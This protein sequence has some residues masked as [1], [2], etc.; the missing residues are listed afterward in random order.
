[1]DPKDA[2]KKIAEALEKLKILSR[3]WGYLELVCLSEG[4]WVLRNHADQ[5]FGNLLGVRKRF[6]ADTPEDVI[7]VA[8]K[9]HETFN[10]SEERKE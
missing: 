9:A 1:M 4:R 2:W 5:E 7:F 8:Y 10:G 3:A 6:E